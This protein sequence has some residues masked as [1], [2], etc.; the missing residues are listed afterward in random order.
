VDP[1]LILMFPSSSDK[2]MASN[3]PQTPTP[4]AL[5]AF[6]QTPECNRRYDESVTRSAKRSAHY[7]G[8]VERIQKDSLPQTFEAL[9]NESARAEASGAQIREA[10]SAALPPVDQENQPSTTNCILRSGKRQRDEDSSCPKR[11]RLE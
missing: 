3:Y 6:V 4:T 5:T 8:V 9:G 11:C 7:L 2:R 10:N 1:E